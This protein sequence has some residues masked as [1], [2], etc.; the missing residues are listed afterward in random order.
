M[1]HNWYIWHLINQNRE[2]SYWIINILFTFICL[3]MLHMPWCGPSEPWD[4]SIPMPIVISV[5]GI[6][7]NPST[8]VWQ[9]I[10]L[11]SLHF[12]SFTSGRHLFNIWYQA[13]YYIQWKTKQIYSARICLGSLD[14]K[15]EH[16]LMVPDQI[17]IEWIVIKLWACILSETYVNTTRWTLLPWST[18]EVKLWYWV[19]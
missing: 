15:G 5:L 3:E 19:W 18:S 9:Y 16:P 11:K 4:I 7:Y 6:W 17:K 2:W 10:T 1:L 12:Y 13:Q 14:Q 8:N